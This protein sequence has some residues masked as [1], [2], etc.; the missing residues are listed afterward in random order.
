MTTS[1]TTVC[2]TT[3]HYSPREG[4]LRLGA[5]P[6]EVQIH[7]ARAAGLPG[8]QVTG[9]ERFDHAVAVQDWTDDDEIAAVHYA[10]AEA[11]IRDITGCDAAL[12][13]DHVKRVAS[14]EK[15][16]R[17]QDPVRL[18]HSDFA[19]DYERVIRP[20][21]HGVKGRGAATLA[22]TGVSAQQIESAE[23]IVMMQLWRNL[24]APKMDFPLAWCDNRTLSVDDAR[25]FPYTG[26]VAGGRRFDAL[27]IAE[28]TPGVG[29]NW[30]AYPDLTVDEV[31]VFRT[32]DTELV[33]RNEVF[34]TP[35]TAF[36]DPDVTPGSPARFSIELRIL[37]LWL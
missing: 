20:A 7:D 22:R 37:C 13:S 34:F 4:D 28:P 27:A 1:A 16:R 23:R 14:A 11:L 24:G 18:V 26:Y 3:L 15:R 36:P 9:F 35:H 10:E 29:H 12:V 25:P 5:A 31:V 33:R 8:W 30:Y 19:A 32:Y 21:Y 17:E 6:V 2:R